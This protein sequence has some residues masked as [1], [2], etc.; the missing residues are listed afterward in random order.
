LENRYD[1]K[2]LD[3]AKT[4][5]AKKAEDVVVLD[6]KHLTIIAD[7]FV[8]AS[9][10]STTHIK[11]LCDELEEELAKKGIFA[12]RKEGYNEAR[13][14]VLDFLDVLVHIFH[15]D[16]R[17]FYNIERLWVDGDNMLRYELEKPEAK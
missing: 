3:M 6:V 7:Y 15:R 5:A 13:W 8:I 9:G 17:E 12:K 4:L 2:V 14:I 16:E 1:E 10:R 11:S